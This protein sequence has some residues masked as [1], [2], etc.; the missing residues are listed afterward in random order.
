MFNQ[1]ITDDVH[2]IIKTYIKPGD[3]VLDLTVG[4]G[5]DTLFLANCV[6]ENGKV[7]GID[8][9]KIALIN[10]KELLDENNIKHV[11]LIEGDHCQL[12]ELISGEFHVA[13]M[14]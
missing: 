11:E 10:T 8:I 3:R 13:M 4:N 14:N 6:G 1:Y 9:Q 12:D 7:I 5:Y 2:D